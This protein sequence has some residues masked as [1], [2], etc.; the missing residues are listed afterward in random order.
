[1]LCGN[2][3]NIGNFREATGWKTPLSGQH[4]R[5]ERKTSFATRFL[6]WVCERRKGFMRN[7]KHVNELL[8]AVWAKGSSRRC[9]AV[10]QP[11]INIPEIRTNSI[12]STTTGDRHIT[13]RGQWNLPMWYT[14]KFLPINASRQA[15][16]LH[17]NG[18]D[19]YGARKTPKCRVYQHELSPNMNIG[20]K[21]R[22]DCI[23]VC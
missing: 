18:K 4:V 19:F 2:V 11:S 1:M 15:Y 7:F 8:T 6:Q 14:K 20:Y 5:N 21:Y 10:E 3:T 9:A 12:C 22:T 17:S 16:E 23:A 13:R